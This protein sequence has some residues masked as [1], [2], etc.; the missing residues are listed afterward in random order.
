ML[1]CLRVRNFRLFSMLLRAHERRYRSFKIAVS[2]DRT[3][4][5]ILSN[6]VTRVT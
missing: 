5:Q 6:D 3:L 1:V 4:D 2:A